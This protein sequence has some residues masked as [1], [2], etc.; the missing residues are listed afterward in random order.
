MIAGKVLGRED[1]PKT[2]SRAEALHIWEGVHGSIEDG[3]LGHLPRSR[4]ASLPRPPESLQRPT[5]PRR[6]GGSAHATAHACARATPNVL[7]RAVP[8]LRAL[9][10]S[11]APKVAGWSRSSPRSTLA[12]LTVRAWGH[13]P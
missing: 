5:T 8:E 7:E 3:S 6:F 4:V 1:S 12:D 11:A 10:S 9:W 2:A 13:V